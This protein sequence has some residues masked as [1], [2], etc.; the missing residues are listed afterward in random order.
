V[1]ECVVLPAALSFGY[2][3][4]GALG[5]TKSPTTGSELWNE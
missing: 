2:G 4:P 3:D 5:T 1:E